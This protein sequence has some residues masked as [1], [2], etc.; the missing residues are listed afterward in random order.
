M[1]CNE[2]EIINV[3]KKLREKE[4]EREGGKE[5]QQIREEVQ[6]CTNKYFLSKDLKR[7]KTLK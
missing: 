2:I 5:R 7:F 3:S 6:K 4:R 1:S